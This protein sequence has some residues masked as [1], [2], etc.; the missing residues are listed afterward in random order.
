[1]SSNRKQQTETTVQIPK[2]SSNTE[3]SKRIG[4]TV[5]IAGERSDGQDY[6]TF[7]NEILEQLITFHF[8][9]NLG[10]TKTSFLVK[11]T[12]LAQTINKYSV[13]KPTEVLQFLAINPHLESIVFEAHD[14]IRTYFEHEDLSLEV[15]S[16]SEDQ[17]AHLV[18]LIKTRKSPQDIIEKLDRFDRG[19]WFEISKRKNVGGKLSVTPVF[20]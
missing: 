3:G 16:D 19:W 8:K 11:K 1:M 15:V 20:E 10:E 12:S 9:S 7:F 17:D 13:K 6:S 5:T 18:I 14:R 2:P 4:Y